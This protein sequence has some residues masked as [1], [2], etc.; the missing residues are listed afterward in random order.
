MLPPE[1]PIKPPSLE[2]ITP[3]GRFKPGEKICTSFTNYHPETWS[4][5]QTIDK[6]LMGLISFMH[7]E[8]ITTGGM[9]TSSSEKRRLARDSLRF[10]MENP[11]F[12]ELFSPYFDRLGITE[13]IQKRTTEP[14]M[15]DPGA[16][17][18]KGIFIV[19]TLGA[20]FVA[21]LLKC[22]IESKLG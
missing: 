20:I 3:S 8:E 2:F 6:M 16:V 21:Y 13:A 5:N 15:T 12:M 9:R 18:R 14:S 1:Y 22:V 19:C 4:P 10:N 17:K 11:L 7:S